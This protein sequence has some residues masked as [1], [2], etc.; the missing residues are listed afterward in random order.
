MFQLRRNLLTCLQQLPVVM[1]LMILCLCFTVQAQEK[2]TPTTA[3]TLRFCYE[4]KALLPYYAGD[5]SAV[6]KEPGASIEHLQAATQLVE[7]KLELIRLPWRRCLQLLEENQVDALIAAYDKDRA[8]FTVYPTDESGAADPSLAINQLGLCLA[9]RYDNP[10]QEKL[11]AKS[12]LSIARPLG[13][14]PLPFLTGTVQ[15]DAHSVQHALELVVSGRVDA[16]TMLC[17]VNGMQAQEQFLYTMPLQLLYPPIH[18]TY[19]YLMLSADF[20]QRHPAKAHKLWQAL[21]A[22][23][24]K[25]RYLYYLQ[26]KMD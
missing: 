17:E 5:G 4:D 9:H 15:V 26:L 3:P 23:L 18:Q 7:M 11:K 10:L 12:S 22:T 8:H 2:Q 25:Q 1:A 19:G 13:Y 14:K 24:D 16:T 21:P 20:Y 6:A